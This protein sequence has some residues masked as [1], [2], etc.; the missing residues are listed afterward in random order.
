MDKDRKA[1]PYGQRL[2]LVPH[3]AARLVASAGCRSFTAQT[4]STAAAE[5][6]ARGQCLGIV[7]TIAAFTADVCAIRRV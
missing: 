3:E 6:F 5:A 7:D 2:L 4:Q 1:K